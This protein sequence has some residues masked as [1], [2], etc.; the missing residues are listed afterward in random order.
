MG[1]RRNSGSPGRGGESSSK[2]LHDGPQ[3]SLGGPSRTPANGFGRCYSVA[4]IARILGVGKTSVRRLLK[5][6]QLEYLRISPRRLVVREC[7][8]REFLAG[9]ASEVEE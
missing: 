6:G 3:R 9:L 8:L 1:P 5:S 4:E 7:D 2:R